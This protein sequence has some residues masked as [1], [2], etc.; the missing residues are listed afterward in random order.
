[1]S[2]WIF[3]IQLCWGLTFSLVEVFFR[4]TRAEIPQR[5]MDLP[6]FCYT[7]LKPRQPSLGQNHSLIN[8]FH[9]VN[10]ALAPPP[11]WGSSPSR[12]PCPVPRKSP[13]GRQLVPVFLHA[14][15][16][17][18][19]LEPG[20]A[21]PASIPQS[22]QLCHS[23]L[24]LLPLPRKHR[25]QSCGTWS[26][27]YSLFSGQNDGSTLENPLEKGWA[28]PCFHQ[29]CPGDFESSHWEPFGCRI[30]SVGHHVYLGL[31]PWPQRK[32]WGISDTQCQSPFPHSSLQG[33]FGSLFNL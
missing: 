23:L 6:L 12:R 25:T 5:W 19:L 1:M 26:I 15:V 8:T 9:R 33:T 24:H 10:G 14:S 2:I 20:N 3:S 21:S 17:P 27:F 30:I 31:W 4:H 28:V 22:P 29:A 18:F 32:R 16:S 7:H 11:A 13:A